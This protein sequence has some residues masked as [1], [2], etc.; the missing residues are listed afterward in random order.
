M[1]K[2]QAKSVFM[3]TG[4]NL[5]SITKCKTGESLDENSASGQNIFVQEE[6]Y[7]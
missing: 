1:E 3:A 4:R 5:T 6:V 7:Y 2:N